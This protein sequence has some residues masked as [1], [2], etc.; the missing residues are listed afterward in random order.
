MMTNVFFALKNIAL[1]SVLFCVN[2]VVYAQSVTINASNTFLACGGGPVQLSATGLT[3]AT[4]FGDDFNAGVLTAGWTTGPAAN[5]SN[6][7]GASFDGST[8]L[9]MGSGTSAPRQ[10][11][12]SNLDVTCG[13]TVCFDFKFVCEY[14]GDV[15]PCEGADFY[16]EGV[17]LQ[18][19][20]NNGVNWIDI[21]YFAPNGNLLTSYPG[22]GT[23]SPVA[24]GA[25]NFTTWANYCFP[26][27]AAAFSNSTQFRL[28][29]W[30]SSGNNY[31]HWGIDN[32]YINSTPC[33]PY[34]YDWSHLPGFPDA[35][36]ITT[37]VTSTTTFSVDYTDGT[38]TYSDQITITVDNLE[39]DTV[40]VTPE[41]C[42]QVDDAMISVT[43]VNGLAPFNYVLN[44][45]VAGNNST[46][47]F[48]N[49]EAGLY[50]LE[51][52]D[53]NNC[54]TS[55]N[56]TIPDGPSCCVVTA[57]GS[58]P[59]CF[60]FTNGNIVSTP[61]GGIPAY[62]YQWYDLTNSPLPGEVSQSIGNIGSGTYIIE[63]TDVS[64]C[65]NRDTVTLLA[66][67][68]LN[69]SLTTDQINCYGI[70]DGEVE[71][72]SPTG[73]VPI[74]T[75]AI[76]GG[77][78]QASN[79]FPNLCQGNYTV[80]IKDANNC[81]LSLNTNITEPAELIL[82][83]TLI[84]NEICS[85]TDGEIYV[86]A[87][88][89]TGLYTYTLG[90]QSNNSGTFTGLSSGN[91]TV[92]VSD[93]SGCIDSV[94]L[95]IPH[96][97][98]PDPVIDYQQDVLCA[99]GINGVVTIV[100]TITTGTA[101]FLFDL[102]NTGVAA[103]NTFNVNA[104][105]HTVDVYDANNCTG[106]VSFSIS[107]P[108]VLSYTT[109]K[110]D[111]NCN[112][113][114]DGTITVNANG[115]TPPYQYS[116][117]GGISFQ[118]SNILTGLCPGNINVVVR[119]ANGCLANSIVV[120]NSPSALNSS[121]TPVDPTCFDGCDGSITFGITSGGTGP[122]DYS[123]DNGVTYQVSPFFVNLCAGVY[124]LIAKDANDC[125][126]IM[127]GVILNNPPQITFNDISNT[128]SNCG[129]TNGGFEVQAQNGLAA[130]T[131]TIDNGATTQATGNFPNLSSGI[132]NVIVTD[133][134]GCVDSTEEG[135]SD[136]EIQT[137]LD[138]TQNITCFGGTDGGVF[139]SIVNGLP[140]ISF[141]LDSVY[142]QNTGDFDGLLNPNV[143]I[144]AGTH[145]VIIHDSGNCSDFYEFTL[146]EP[147]SITYTLNATDALCVGSSD[148]TITFSNVLGGD[149]GPYTYSID[150]G[151][152][153]LNSTVFA[154]LSAGVYNTMVMDGNGCLGGNQITI[155]DADSIF[156]SLNP[157][158]LVCHGDN[159]GSLIV[160]AQGG[161]GTFSY[162]IGTANNVT[163]IFISL[164][165]SLYN[166]TVTDGNGCTEDTVQLIAQPDTITA[167]FT[168]NQNL[169]FNN[170][171]GEIIIAASGGTLPYLF[172][173]NGGI[174]QQASDT[175]I[176]LCANLYNVQIS[177]FNGCTYNANQTI[178]EPT[179]LQLTLNATNSV[180]GLNN[181]V[182]TATESGGTGPFLFAISNN[183]GSTYSVPG[184]S[185]IFSNLAPGY[186]IVKVIDANGCEEEEDVIMV[187]DNLP[188]IDFIQTTDILCNGVNN[189]QI[190]VTSGL[191]VGLHEYSLDNINYSPVNTFN[192]LAAGNYDIYL[193]DGNSCV[194]VGNTVITEP[195]TL[196]SNVNVTD[197]ICNNDFTGEI[198]MVP[199]GGTPNYTYSIDNGTS[200]HPSGVFTSLVANNYTTIVADANGCTDTFF[201]TINEPL[202]IITP[203]IVVT[204]AICFGDCNGSIDLDPSGG[205]GA[206][207]FQWTGNI[208]S[209]IDPIAT[210]VCAGIYEAIITDANGCILTASNLQVNQ[211][212]LISI[213]NVIATD[214]SCYNACGGEIE[215]NSNTAVNYEIIFNGNTTA[216]VNNLFTGL[217]DGNYDII[218]YDANSCSATSN[219]TILE[220]DTLVGQ[221]PSDWTNICFGTDINVTSG[222][223][224]G[225]T[226]PYILDWV[227]SDGN[228]YP[229]QNTF[230]YTANQNVTFTY[231]IT[232]ANGCSAGPYSY[233][234]TTSF[235]LVVN[236]G[237]DVDICPGETIELN[238]SA[239]GGQMDDI[240][241]GLDYHYSWNPASPNDTI[242][243]I[244][245]SPLTTT[246]Y[247]FTAVDFCQD[248]VSDIVTVT[249]HPDPVPV[250]LGDT[251]ACAPY[252]TALTNG[253]NIF[254]SDYLWEFS[255]G[256]IST[257]PIARETFSVP[258]CYDVTLTVTSPEDCIGS[259][260]VQNAVCIYPIPIASFEYA[261]IKPIVTDES[262]QFTNESTNA[263]GFYWEF[264]DYGISFEENPVFNFDFE[265][266][267]L[268]TV[269]LEATTSF[270][271]SDDTCLRII[272]ADDLLFYV[273]NA[274]TPDD[275]TVN[276]DFVPVFTAG[277]DPYAYQL[278]IYNRWGEVVFISNNP[279]MGWDG[280]YGEL[281]AQQAVYVWKIRYVETYEG[282]TKEITGHVTLLR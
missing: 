49:L 129:F 51:V 36:S 145:F 218:V 101:P 69:G 102:N 5:F 70:C 161:E 58:D 155:G 276:S 180:C 56:F 19:T 118:T 12:T 159:S 98:G 230:I 177:D 59:S 8:Y 107:Q 194:V 243:G 219:T 152:T 158:N 187:G 140:P 92:E 176:N 215:I 41:T 226:T 47:T 95:F 55:Y 132:Y 234:I 211:P 221:A 274:F 262:I 67:P 183:N 282:E 109:T 204:D 45:P 90:L 60:G 139:V 281:I 125:E 94:Q 93:A 117:D 116:S 25:T 138:S 201:V 236:A 237:L 199:A 134:N 265:T 188:T 146:F 277:F 254:G 252:T 259:S 168:I 205:T 39:I 162:D 33:T 231:I 87:I 185:N 232:D 104:G 193:R 153:Y 30:G 77:T 23:T 26:V 74:Y 143:E 126:F 111:A 76:N 275:G 136:L 72:D 91:Y 225:G 206:L 121:N 170:C 1:I 256:A 37:N 229:G 32:F 35:A 24:F 150:S 179:D 124:D 61:S 195:T 164:G 100:V 186:Y 172:S 222:L 50:V 238:G 213:T 89:G 212:P 239:M 271:C 28:Y 202:P 46:G 242:T 66:P 52:I 10:L 220:P 279:A 269:C 82:I 78:Y 81:V 68:V 227:D 86:E 175:I 75:Y 173:P 223:T 108:T 240:G 245:V 110:T 196:V 280:Q 169:C 122:Y 178:T 9:W 257:D 13:G 99:G 184:A 203:N 2:D 255:T 105:N 133:A 27:P 228:L 103:M 190:I 197:L 119:D 79:T 48:T 7:C 106:S 11:A 264:D 88:G 80:T 38:T 43:M 217:C 249:V 208:A 3:S 147:D 210:N 128:S 233:D 154:G 40:I 123:I 4:V 20:I 97:L 130:Y 135:V 141:T 209:V 268:L 29:Q 71:F 253:N 192:N 31:D 166:V 44:G 63:I 127:A 22:A 165:A 18:Y 248:T 267:T 261:P 191:G 258:G 53:A 84:N 148:G 263:S 251:S 17:S 198:S 157:S 200:Y 278:S 85:Q 260:S 181:G 42:Y 171:D 189:G 224:T 244:S 65:I 214:D 54:Q 250:I 266:E 246:D 6:P 96:S 113:S 163:G 137:S 115:A 182:I 112:T 167:N 149:G 83:D 114:C 57:T 34:Y 15:S 235:P 16:N 120:I 131:Y 62:T 142:F 144:T 151:M 273:P 160:S 73:G 241:T 174:S 272:I 207:S 156:V 216:S 64:G 247:T 270:G 21:A 14:C